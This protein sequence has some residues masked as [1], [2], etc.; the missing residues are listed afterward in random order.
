MYRALHSSFYS[1]VVNNSALKGKTKKQFAI[2]GILLR[3]PTRKVASVSSA[4]L[5]SPL[6]FT[7]SLR[8][9][10]TG[11][12][13]SEEFL[14]CKFETTIRYCT[15][16]ELTEIP[17]DSVMELLHNTDYCVTLQVFMLFDKVHNY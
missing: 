14:D 17:V 16:G 15:P 11:G 1:K 10:G 9:F 7:V 6:S 5:N 4:A 2:V 13:I 12:Q 8:R 3:W